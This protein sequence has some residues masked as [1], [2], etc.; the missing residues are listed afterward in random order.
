M[1]KKFFFIFSFFSALLLVS[2]GV[3]PVVEP[4]EVTHPT[5]KLLLQ[6]ET[7]Y[8]SP[9]LT[10]KTETLNGHYEGNLSFSG[11]QNVMIRL[12]GADILL[13]TAIRD[14]DISVEEITAY[15]RV[16]AR[17]GFCTETEYTKNG[18]S[19]FTYDYG[20]YRLKTIDDV[21]ETPDGQSHRIKTFELQSASVLKTEGYGSFYGE[22]G[23]IDMENWGI[24]LVLID[25]DSKGV[26]LKVRQA[27]GQQLGTLSVVRYYLTS[28]ENRN[29]YYEDNSLLAIPLTMDGTTTFH[30]DWSNENGPLS[31]GHYYLVIVL[32]DNY[33]EDLLT[34]MI[35]KFHDRQSYMVEFTLETAP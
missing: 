33:P 7:G 28:Q 27:D 16:D 17:N 32:Q 21:Y 22:N 9:F 4:T 14:G 34:P 3:H 6:Y 18:L 5:Q 29:F 23:E 26:E 13:E 1:S 30:L 11:L 10:I 24:Q 25:Y 35:R 20:D 2:C 12:N 31:A 15:A 8:T 19:Q